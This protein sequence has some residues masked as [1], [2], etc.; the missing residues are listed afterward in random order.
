VIP[1][2]ATAAGLALLAVGYSLGARQAGPRLLSWAE[3]ATTPGWRTW[4]FWLGAPVVILALA[5][6][7][8]V[9]PRRTLAN[10]RA[11]RQPPPARGPALTF[12]HDWA[13]KRRAA[14]HTEET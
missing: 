1:L 2:T 5:W 3:D 12:D 6:M 10:V 8:I 13:A 9:H 7:W 14:A 4:R 11:W